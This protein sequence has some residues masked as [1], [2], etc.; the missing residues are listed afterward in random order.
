MVWFTDCRSAFDTLQKPVAKTVDKRLGIEL[1]SP[2]QHL[3]RAP[4]GLLPE[5]RSLEERPGETSYILFWIDTSVM[6][7]DCLT[8]Q[9]RED[10]LQQVLDLNYWGFTQTDEAKA[11]KARKQAQRR[12]TVDDDLDAE[13]QD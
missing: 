6:I 3:W 11:V 1:A 10:E 7:A 9:M 4:G 13:A 8:K 5:R 2:R 12:K